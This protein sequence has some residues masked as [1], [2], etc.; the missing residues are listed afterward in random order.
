MADGGQHAG[1]LELGQHLDLRV[2]GT[3]AFGFELDRVRAALMPEQQVRRAWND[4]QAF[5]DGALDCRA[6]AAIGW[7]QK[8]HARSAARFQMRD[9]GAVNLLFRT[10]ATDCG[11]GADIAAGWI[12]VLAKLL[13][14]F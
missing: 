14:L 5:E 10:L 8:H 7:M 12:C 4:A 6:S 13:N 2:A 11:H 9:N 1:V 3:A